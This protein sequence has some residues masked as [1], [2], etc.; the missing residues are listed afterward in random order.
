MTALLHAG[1]RGTDPWHASAAPLYQTATF[2]QSRADRFDT[3]DYTRTDNPTRALL[4]GR[5]AALERGRHAL[6]YA[7]GMAA[8]D[9]LLALVPVGGRLVVGR[10]LYGGTLRLVGELARERGVDVRDEDS[11][12]TAAFARAIA[13]HAPHWVL[14][15]SPTNPSQD[16]TDIAAAARAAR[17]AGARLAVDN[18]ML[19]GW[20]QQP[21]ELGADAVLVSATKHLGGHGDVTAGAVVVRDAGLHAELARRRNTHGTALAPFEAWL[22]ARG[23]DTLGLR[24]ERSQASALAVAR[25]LDARPDV[26]RVRYAGLASHPGHGLLARQ[27][28]GAGTVVAFETGDAGLSRRLVEAL[29][30]FHVAVSFG[31][32]VSTAS[33]PFAM[34]HAS[35]PAGLSATIAPPPRDLVRLSIGLEEPCD[36]VDDLE[37]AF[38]EAHAAAGAAAPAPRAL[39]Q[40][41]RLP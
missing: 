4:E 24:I 10:D 17:A 3:Y 5:L 20:L 11:G 33:L 27:A 30:L 34:S 18:T 40:A 41:S 8:V 22:L 12:D 1:R 13:E 2:V 37:R 21:L 14:V 39:V 15:E 32:T 6:A 7:S 16:V 19:S 38:A 35:V 28:R 25:A 9:A 31:S 23:L 26:R 36:L 29:R